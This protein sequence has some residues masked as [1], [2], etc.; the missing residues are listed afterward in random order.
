M[1]TPSAARI[2]SLQDILREGSPLP[3]RDAAPLSAV[4]Q[5]PIRHDVAHSN[6]LPEILG[7]RLLLVDSS[8]ASVYP[9]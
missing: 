3:L 5:M 8:A 7:G 2:G 1:K 4:S 9:L 6:G